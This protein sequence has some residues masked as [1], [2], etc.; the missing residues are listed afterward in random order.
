MKIITSLR[1]KRLFLELCFSS[2]RTPSWILTYV[3]CGLPA[4]DL[5][6]QGGQFINILQNKTID[7]LY[8]HC[9]RCSRIL[10]TLVLLNANVYFLE[11]TVDQNQL[12][13]HEAI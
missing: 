8:I 2:A 4:D 10:L 12:A 13:S 3:N 7:T 11:N 6:G 9:V 1:S 5:W